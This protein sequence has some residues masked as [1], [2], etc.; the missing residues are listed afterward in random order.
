M[1]HPFVAKLPKA[2]MGEGVWLI[3]SREDWRRYCECT[4]VLYAQE[5]LPLDRD[6]R[7]VVVG[8]RVVTAYWRTQADQGFY[9]NVARGGRIDNSPVPR[10]MTDLALRLA[11]E[12]DVDHAG[13]DIALVEGYPYVLEFNRLFGN[14]GLGKGRELQDAILAYLRQQSEPRDP[15]GPVE[16]TPPW[17][18]AV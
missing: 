18:V 13:F 16:P 10:V 6:A 3:E 8:D 17:P 5:Y 12:L 9:N 2:S 7:I 11:R 1:T 4:D 15:D 14:Q